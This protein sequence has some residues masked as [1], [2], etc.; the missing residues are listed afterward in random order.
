MISQGENKKEICQYGRLGNLLSMTDLVMKLTR[1]YLSFQ[2]E[3]GGKDEDGEETS[4]KQE[5]DCIS[6]DSCHETTQSTFY[7]LISEDCFDIIQENLADCRRKL[8]RKDA[9]I[10]IRPILRK[11]CCS[12]EEKVQGQQYRVKDRQQDQDERQDKQ[13]EQQRQL[14][15]EEDEQQHYHRQKEQ[16]KQQSDDNHN[17]FAN[18]AMFQNEYEDVVNDCFAQQVLTRIHKVISR[19]EKEMQGIVVDTIMDHATKQT[20]T[21]TAIMYVVVSIF[22]SCA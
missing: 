21:A 19:M 11:P 2:E 5:R 10:L 9:T 6:T 20:D 7:D 12:E 17:E 8:V 4:V 15:Q 13:L 16:E 14:Q 1:L 18:L 22:K 3:G